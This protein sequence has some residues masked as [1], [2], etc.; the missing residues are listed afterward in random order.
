MQT[1]QRLTLPYDVLNKPMQ[2]GTDTVYIHEHTLPQ[3]TA[4]KTPQ[5][6]YTIHR[7]DNNQFLA[8][9]SSDENGVPFFQA[10][11]L[12]HSVKGVLP[13]PVIQS[14]INVYKKGRVYDTA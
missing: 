6:F 7:H 1:K 14:K 4:D 8:T 11:I 3:A 2:I 9:L 10:E 13:L 5:F 12:G